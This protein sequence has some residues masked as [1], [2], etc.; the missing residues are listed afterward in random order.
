MIVEAW[1]VSIAFFHEVLVVLI[2]RWNIPKHPKK[3][4]AGFIKRWRKP[5]WIGVVFLNPW[6]PSEQLW[7]WQNLVCLEVNSFIPTWRRRWENSVETA[8]KKHGFLPES[9]G[10]FLVP[11]WFCECSC[12]S[13]T[14][15]FSHAGHWADIDASFIPQLFVAT[16][17]AEQKQIRK[18]MGL[19]PFGQ[20]WVD[21]M[22]KQC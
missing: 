22:C 4:I 12:L 10:R 3:T 18:L 9:L 7:D 15:S 14:T 11:G 8:E 20:W 5:I 6:I 13:F 21:R 17:L 16:H 19:V 1:W 2:A